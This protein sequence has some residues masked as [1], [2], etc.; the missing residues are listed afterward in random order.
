LVENLSSTEEGVLGPKND[1]FSQSHD[2]ATL[3]NAHM[4]VVSRTLCAASFS[5]GS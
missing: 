3:C 4:L 5:F 1:M 2:Q